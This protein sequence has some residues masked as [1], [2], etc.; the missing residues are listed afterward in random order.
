M[1]ITAVFHSSKAVLLRMANFVLLEK[2]DRMG[3]ANSETTF[4]L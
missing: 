4:D 1:L 2:I 3:V